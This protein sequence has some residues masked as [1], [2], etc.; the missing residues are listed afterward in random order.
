MM[1]ARLQ[2]M[3]LNK[4]CALAKGY[5]L[6]SQAYKKRDLNKDCA[7]STRMVS[8]SIEIKFANQNIT[9]IKVDREIA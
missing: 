4:L 5:V 9:E 3:Q 8:L 2:N 1:K 7:Q 6:R